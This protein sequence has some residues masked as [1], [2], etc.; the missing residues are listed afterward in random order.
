MTVTVTAAA[1]AAVAVLVEVQ[2]SFVRWV[3]RSGWIGTRAALATV[4]SDREH[5]DADRLDSWSCLEWEVAGLVELVAST[6]FVQL[7]SQNASALHTESTDNIGSSRC[8]DGRHRDNAYSC[9][10]GRS[11]RPG[12]V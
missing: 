1:A 5:G 11:Q 2:V 8:P 4:G 10:R 9:P 12:A 3:S 6:A 7:S